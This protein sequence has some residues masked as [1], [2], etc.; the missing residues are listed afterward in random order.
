MI[1]M[2]GGSLNLT[3]FRKKIYTTKPYYDCRTSRAKGKKTH[4]HAHKQYTA[5]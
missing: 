1:R 5:C 4:T 2:S 3:E